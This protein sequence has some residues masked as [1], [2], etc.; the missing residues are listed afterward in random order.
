MYRRNS[1]RQYATAW[2]AAIGNMPSH[3]DEKN[4]KHSDADIVTRAS[5]QLPWSLM[6]CLSA[7]AVPSQ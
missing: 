4:I 6:L 3:R 5:Q 2:H 7:I 1:S